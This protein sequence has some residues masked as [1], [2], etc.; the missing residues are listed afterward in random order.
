M[1]YEAR[2]DEELLELAQAGWRGAFAVLVHR[3]APALLT[4]FADAPDPVDRTYD[5]LLRA[6][7]H[8]PEVDPD[9]VEVRSWLFTLAGRMPPTRVQSPLEATVDRIW[10]DLDARWPDGVSHRTTRRPGLVPFA[11]V[12]GAI[13]LGVAVPVVVLG[14]PAASSDVPPESIRA[15]PIDETPVEAPDPDDLPAFEFPDV[16]DPTAPPAQPEPLDGPEEPETT[17]DPPAPVPDEGEL[18]PGTGSPE[19]PTTPPADDQA[20]VPPDDGGG[21]L[22]DGGD[23]GT[24]DGG[25]DVV[26]DGDG[27][28]DAS[29]DGASDGGTGGVVGVIGGDA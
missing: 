22:P 19:Q 15:Q 2:S 12:L 3:H 9:R 20:P 1:R 25:G 11:T 23:P 21:D 7:R 4:A 18:E 29:D 10:L 28:G 16:G 5:V 8:L 17:I 6:M 13:A 27:G 14:L 24:G 26:G